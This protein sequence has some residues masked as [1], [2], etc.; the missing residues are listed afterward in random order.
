MIQKSVHRLLMTGFVAFIS[1]LSLM[2]QHKVEMLPFGDMD[3]WVDRQIKE[4][5]IIGGNTKN[6]YAIGPTTV[7]KGDQVYKNMGGSP[8]ATSNVMAKVAGITKTNTSVFPEKRGDGYCA[9][10]DTRMESVKVLGL[11]NITVLAAGSVF[12]GSVHEPIKGTKNPQKMLQ[13]GIPDVPGK[14]YPAAI[15]LLQKRW[16]D[17]NGNVYAK[18]IGTMVTYY[19]HSTDWKNNAT[20]EIMYGDITN[21]PEY[22]SHMMR[23]QV[24]ESYTVNSKGESVPIHEVAWGD[25]NDV[26]THMCLQFTSSHG[27]AYIGSPGNTLWID[28]VKLVY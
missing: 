10:L 17:A 26:P 4:S 24:T 27:G 25:E 5:S 19:Y 15:L 2:A 3:Q 6:V 9:R 14:D 20:Y 16:E 18:R 21:R 7:I 8:W 23:L 13:T 22:K 1:S 28:N 12:T 11:V